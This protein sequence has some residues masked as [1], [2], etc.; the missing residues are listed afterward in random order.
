MR[1]AKT[2]TEKS[3][4]KEILSAVNTAG[5]RRVPWRESDWPDMEGEKSW[6]I[7]N[8]IGVSGRYNRGLI[9]RLFVLVDHGLLEMRRSPGNRFQ[10]SGALMAVNDI[11][12]AGNPRFRVAK[13]Q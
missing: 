8:D 7:P 1:I 5:E 11:C 2:V 10:S 3:T 6:V 12:F 4:D 9:K 13:K